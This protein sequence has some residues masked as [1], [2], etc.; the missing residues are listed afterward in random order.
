M[1]GFRTPAQLCLLD[2][3]WPASETLHLL[4]RKIRFGYPPKV[5]QSGILLKLGY[6]SVESLGRRDPMHCPLA[7][8][9]RNEMP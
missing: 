8:H 2:L 3:P 7:F 1:G 6:E 4:S 5:D 9:C